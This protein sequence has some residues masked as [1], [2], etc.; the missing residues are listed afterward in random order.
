MSGFI[1]SYIGFQGLPN[2]LSY[3]SFNKITIV[4]TLNNFSTYRTSPKGNNYNFPLPVAIIRV[5][6]Y[7]SLFKTTRGQGGRHGTL[8]PQVQFVLVG[9]LLCNAG[10]KVRTSRFAGQG[11]SRSIPCPPP[12]GLRAK[13]R[14]R[15]AKTGRWCGSR[16]VSSAANF[17]RPPSRTCLLWSRNFAISPGFQGVI[18]CKPPRP[19]SRN[20]LLWRMKPFGCLE[21]TLFCEEETLLFL[22]GFR[23]HLLI[24]SFG[25]LEEITFLCEVGRNTAIS[26]GFQV[27]INSFGRLE[28]NCF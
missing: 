17:L 9:G 20:G 24:H 8:P 23:V 2:K 7:H 26:K 22:R 10:Q 4:I 18:G 13:R 12:E 25:R 11:W 15:P 28:K 16:R 19:S 1:Q 5:V 6:F 21:E 14:D 27:L 3:S